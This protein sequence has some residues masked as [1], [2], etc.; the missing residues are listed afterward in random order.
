MAILRPSFYRDPPAQFDGKF[1]WEF[2]RECFPT[3]LSIGYPQYSTPTDI[4]GVVEHRGYFLGFETKSPGVEVKGGQRR[5]IV[6]CIQDP[7]WSFI[8]CCK[9]P[10]QI[11]RFAYVSRVGSCVVVGGAETLKRFCAAWWRYVERLPEIK[12]SDEWRNQVVPPFWE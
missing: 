10:E 1:F 4:D 2:L 3:G 9:R 7:R 5:F 11:E 8:C 6:A 12:A